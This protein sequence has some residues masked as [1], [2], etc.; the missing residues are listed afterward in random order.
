MVW[1][2]GGPGLDHHVLQ[3]LAERLAP[4]FRSQ[5]PDLPGHG[6]THRDLDLD[7]T[8]RELRRTLTR[9]GP[10]AVWI[11]HSLGA[12]LLR[13]LL[14]RE[15]VPRPA[16]VV[17]L[18]PPAGDRPLPRASLPR[19]VRSDPRRLRRELEAQVQHETGH[20]PDRA[21]TE[22]L[23]DAH[24]RA[25]EA[26][27][28]LLRSVWRAMHRPTPP[29]DP[30]C[31]VLLVRGTE[32]TVVGPRETT[33]IAALTEGAQL[34]DVPGVGHFPGASDDGVAEVIDGFLAEVLGS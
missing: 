11:G 26:H 23:A 16:A 34:A 13:E 19:R 21:F 33:E 10:G 15:D 22:A 7:A 32:D 1:I 2:H 8:L 20:A 18:A 14:R 5:L 24:L 17:W 31:P 25:P 12:W 4:R 6:P 3:P 27:Q 9:A 30:G 29:C 28:R